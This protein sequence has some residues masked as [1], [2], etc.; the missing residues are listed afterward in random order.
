MFRFLGSLPHGAPRRVLLLAVDGM[1]A[2]AA[3]HAAFDLRFDG[4]PPA[5]WD[6]R[7]P[8]LLALVAGFQ[9]LAS[10]GCRIHRWSFRFSGLADAG[11]VALAG[12]TAS[13]ALVLATIALRPLGGVLG[14]EPS[15]QVPPRSALV[16]QFLLQLAALAAVRFGPRLWWNQRAHWLRVRQPGARALIFGAGAAGEMLLRDLDRSATHGYRVLGFVDDDPAKRHLILG[17]RPVLGTG[18][19]LPAL[20]ARFQVSDVLL[21]VPRIAP[22]RLRALLSDCARSRLRLRM[23]RVSAFDERAGGPQGALS[24]LAPRDL[25]P[26][27]TVS[28]VPRPGGPRE[29]VALVTG[30]A[31]SIGSEIATQLLAQGVR[32]VVLADRNENDLYLLGRRLA[33]RYGA[34]AVATELVDVRDGERVA[35]LFAEHRP[36]DVFHCAA[37]KHVPLLE[38]EPAAAV[39]TNV[40]GS[41]VVCEAAVRAGAERFV[42]LSTD[43]A[44]EPTSVMGASKRLA[45]QVVLALGR[46]SATTRVSTVRFGNVLGSA[47]SVVPLFL[48]QIRAGGPVTVTDPRVRR[49][50]MTCEEAV[51]LVLDAAYADRGRLFVLEM[52][53]PMAI[54]DLASHLVTMAGLVPDVDVRIELVGLRPGE[55]LEERL[56]ADAEEAAS[57]RFD[58]VVV[59]APR[60]VPAGLLSALRAASARVLT[61]EEAAELLVRWVDDYTPGEDVQA[62]LRP[63]LPAVG[64]AR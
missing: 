53:A 20:V 3:L 2:A 42:L 56:L 43:K 44:V 41:L 31:G 57:E 58:G 52:G 39:A 21:A 40:G 45:E 16:L 46:E 54:L 1:L 50:F 8:A 14:L 23:L 34:A 60:A 61:D 33:A 29:R 24:E 59:A 15:W 48:E 10:F 47:G 25:L 35:R 4:D 19:D 11:R 22:A 55:K 64:G 28:F 38:L 18:A 6:R 17:G 51:G 63:L 26:R 12:A 32:R 27:P 30:G 49:F 7:L 5:V 37:L 9:V 36:Q 13:A 62:L